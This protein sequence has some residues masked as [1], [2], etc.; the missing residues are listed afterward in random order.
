MAADPELVLA[1]TSPRRRDLLGAL[2]FTFRAESPG[3]DEARRPGEAPAAYA[4]R[5]AAEKARAVAERLEAPAHVLGADTVVVLGDEVLG[6]P[7][8]AEEAAEMIR[9]LSGRAHEVVTGIALQAPDVLHQQAVIT[10][11]RFRPLSE[12]EIAWYV[13][14]G[15]AFDAAGA[16]KLQGL[17]GVLVA[18]ID[19]SHSNVIG[20]PL[21]ETV[22]LL[23]TAG[24][25]L[26][27]EDQG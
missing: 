10:R 11:V 23:A 12:R 20:L 17:G 6:K 26:P 9:A 5:L 27:W 18:T 2:G 15:E 1:S 4:R 3:I 22:A 8:G 24:V 21:A 16:Y 13:G 7:S 25:R 14:T 19:G